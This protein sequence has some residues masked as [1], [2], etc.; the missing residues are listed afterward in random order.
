[1]W[2]SFFLASDVTWLN[3]YYCFWIIDQPLIEIQTVK[4][5]SRPFK[6]CFYENMFVLPKLIHSECQYVLRLVHLLWMSFQIRKHRTRDSKWCSR[7]WNRITSTIRALAP[8]V[9]LIH[10]PWNCELN[11]VFK[12]LSLF[13]HGFWT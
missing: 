7:K 11:E 8:G 12:A 9:S 6:A 1:M 5:I 4:H 13:F 3:A 10:L 2:T